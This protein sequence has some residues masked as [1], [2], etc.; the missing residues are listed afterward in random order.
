[1]GGPGAARICPTVIAFVDELL[2]RVLFLQADLLGQA[3]I[4]IEVLLVQRVFVQARPV[5]YL[6]FMLA[7]RVTQYI[8]VFEHFE[9]CSLIL[10]GENGDFD[11]H[12]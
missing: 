5:L 7:D 11:V 4:F 12:P 1:M 6:L 2:L 10:G 3:Q 8:F 9:G